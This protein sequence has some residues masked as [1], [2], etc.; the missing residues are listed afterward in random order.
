MT[1]AEALQVQES[2]HRLQQTMTA[3]ERLVVCP[4]SQPHWLDEVRKQ[5]RA[6]RNELETHYELLD[7]GEYLDEV[8]HQAPRLHDRLIELHR[9]QDL[10]LSEI[11]QVQ[12]E[13][14]AA[15]FTLPAQTLPRLRLLL[16][17]IHDHETRKNLLVL[18]AFN[19]E[20]AALD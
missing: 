20:A 3:L 19:T 13:L 2:Y 15:R 7:M 4:T 14:E 9:E 8:E 6:F 18:E 1:P 17:H 12:D 16:A 10:I 5:T 11:V